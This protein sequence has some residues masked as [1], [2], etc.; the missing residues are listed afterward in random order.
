MSYNDLDSNQLSE[1]ATTAAG[2]TSLL[3]LF[4]ILGRFFWSS[5]SDKYGRKV[6]YSVFFILQG[7]LYFSIPQFAKSGNLHLFVASFCLILSMY[8]GAFAAIPAYA[9][10]MFGTLHIAAIHGRILSSWSTAGIIGPAL[11]YYMRNYQLDRE[12]PI[13]DAYNETMYIMVGVLVIG[14][15]C[16]LLI[17]SVEDKWFMTDEEIAEEKRM[18]TKILSRETFLIRNS[19]QNFNR[20]GESSIYSLVLAWAF[21]GIPILW[22]M[23]KTLIVAYQLF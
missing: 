18:D 17:F 6:I 23:Y 9:A 3:S 14:L 1:I 15:I 7:F 2:F 13:K 22:G 16:N 4:N 21:V 12:V 19:T 8:G 5:L 20:D 10:D 11:V